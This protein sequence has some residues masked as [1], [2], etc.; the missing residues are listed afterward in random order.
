VLWISTITPPTD[1]T[2]II[3]VAEALTEFREH[4]PTSEPERWA[5]R[6]TAAEQWIERRTGRKLR[7]QTVRVDGVIRLDWINLVAVPVAPVVTVVSATV[8]GSAIDPATCTIF[9]EAMVQ[10][11]STTGAVSGGTMAV[12]DSHLD[13]FTHDL[14]AVRGVDGGT[15]IVLELDVGYASGA[16]PEPIRQAMFQLVG[17]WSEQREAASSAG[18]VSGTGLW[19]PVPYELEQ[20]LELYAVE[21]PGP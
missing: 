21:S 1:T 7:R 5:E 18:G 17:L 4:D 2:P 20:T 12:S 13:W 6:I 19:S 3:T 16:V 14:V 9:G 11:G 8:G 10:L 15:S